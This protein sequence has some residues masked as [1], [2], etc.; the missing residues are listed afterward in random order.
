[1]RHRVDSKP[2]SRIFPACQ[3]CDGRVLTYTCS[4]LLPYRYTCI[5]P[6]EVSNGDDLSSDIVV[7]SVERA[8][9]DEAVSH[10]NP[11]LHHL[12]DLPQDLMS[13]A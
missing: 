3:G 2:F 5:V 7:E 4:V 8:G 10:P 6:V 11:R 9:E 12:W 13:R 1:M